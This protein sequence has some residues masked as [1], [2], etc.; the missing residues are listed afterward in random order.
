MESGRSKG[1][2]P[3]PKSGRW[4]NPQ[5]LQLKVTLFLLFGATSALIPYLTIHMQSIGLTVEEVA[6]VYLT[7][8]FTSC[9]SPPLTGFLIDRFGRY[10][11]V[12]LSSIVLN[13]VAHH[14]IHF[15]PPRADT[16]RQHTYSVEVSERGPFMHIEVGVCV[17]CASVSSSDEV[18]LFPVARATWAA[19]YP[20]YLYAANGTSEPSCGPYNVSKCVLQ[21]TDITIVTELIPSG[22]EYDRTFWMYLV[23]RF[24]ATS[25]LASTLTITDPIALDMIEQHG[26]DFGREKLFSSVGMAIFTPLTGLMIDVMSRGKTVTVYTPAFYTYDALLLCSLVSVWLMPIG[27]KTPS[28]NVLRDL[29]KL[30]RLPHVLAF[31]AFLFLLGNFWGFIESYLF[32]IMTAMGSPNYLLG[33]TYTVGTVASIPMMALLNRITHRV[34]HVNLLVVAFFAHAL[35]IL[36]YSW[37]SN[38]FWCFPIELNEAISCYFMWVVATTYCAVLAP[39]SMVATLIGVAGMVHFCLGKGIGS[40]IGGFLIARVGL[41]LAFRYVGYT[42]ACCGV[43]YKLVHLLWLH[44]YDRERP[45]KAV[46]ELVRRR[47]SIVPKVDQFG[48]AIS[49]TQPKP[50]HGDPE[51]V[52]EEQLPLEKG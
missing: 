50:T 41:K 43:L 18:Y 5:L 32:V 31:L 38:P 30:L 26:G 37:I 21:S 20:A 35:R 25:M 48:S 33:L 22:S 3:A 23:V 7:L 44:K 4:F 2:V 45:T 8:L 52:P 1:D 9:L 34:G 27:R 47:A 49:F 42:A 40:F 11:P 28:E 13:L 15:I 19:N 36:G 29:G 46:V 10:K 24:V 12:L 17:G 14:C 39:T 16:V 6:S 51:D